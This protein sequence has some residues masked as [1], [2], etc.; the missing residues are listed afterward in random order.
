MSKFEN[1]YRDGEKIPDERIREIFCPPPLVPTKFNR[2]SLIIGSKGAG[3]TTL[4]RY[5]KSIHSGIALHVS[6][7]TEFASLA[8]QSGLG[9]LAIQYPSD[10]EPLLIGKA[11]SLLAISIS[12]RLAKKGI[13]S[14]LDALYECL[15][16]EF[17]DRTSV[18]ESWF[19][20]TKIKISRSPIELFRDISQTNPLPE[21]LSLLGEICLKEKGNLLLLLDRADMVPGPA[22][23]PVLELLDQASN[24]IAL[25]ATRPGHGGTAIIRHSEMS[26]PGDH[27]DIVHLGIFPRSEDWED[28]VRNAIIA[29][30]GDEVFSK[31]NSDIKL[32]IIYLSRDSIRT[33]LELISGIEATPRKNILKQFYSVVDD[34]KEINLV[35][36]QRTLRQYHP[37]FRKLMNEI[38]DEILTEKDCIDSPVILSISLRTPDDLFD[39]KKQISFFIEASLRSG[40]LCL[41]EGERWIPGYVPIN[42]EIPPLLLWRHGDS[43]NIKKDSKPFQVNR[44]ET[45]VLRIEGGPPPKP[46]LFVAYRM[47]F[48]ESRQ[49]RISLE[50]R[51]QAHPSLSQFVVDDGKV[52]AGANWPNVIRDRIK[53]TK[54][55]VADVT[56]MRSD[57]LFEVG[58][59][60]GLNRSVIPVVSEP[61]ERNKLPFWLGATQIGHYADIAGMSGIISSIES[62]FYDAEFARVKKHPPPVPSLAV[63][64]RVHD[65][66]HNASEQ[67]ETLTL[68]EGLKVEVYSED[69]PEELLI[70]RGG[71]A[72]LLVVSL[73][74]TDWDALMHFICGIV[75]SQ[76]TAGYGRIFKR[77]IIVL[78]PPNVRRRQFVAESVSRCQDT[79][80]ISSVHRV[81]KEIIEFGQSYKAWI[82]TKPKNKRK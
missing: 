14:P 17:F 52:P 2:S 53:K 27:Y 26:I 37:D 64:I 6:L 45:K 34:I 29:Q 9:P 20:E 21:F 72:S 58:F 74:G 30:V 60:F 1:I 54:A 25:V 22:I 7:A 35:A 59:A 3:K 78:E 68:R 62:H 5:Q 8:K 36:I 31:L 28:F 77:R 18:D 23:V 66:N 48:P 50:E 38:R 76:P 24:Y 65:W 33:A 12:T 55:V 67:F 70:R 32:G 19:T 56:R 46:T 75:V 57:V 40:A 43:L 82:G 11:I 79:V 15:P 16:V 80:L 4:F 69:N 42:F 10:I 44:R 63:W 81:A 73:D 49:F 47:D 39:T 61:G 51:L 71:S 13:I 41:P